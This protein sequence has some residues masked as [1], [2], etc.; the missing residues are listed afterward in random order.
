MEVSIPGNTEAELWLPAT[1]DRVINNNK[2]VEPVK[3]EEFAGRK[4]NVYKLSSGIYTIHAVNQ[5]S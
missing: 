5:K 3:I 1:F 4:R 2:I